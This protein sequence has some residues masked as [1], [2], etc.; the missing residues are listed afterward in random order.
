MTSPKTSAPAFND[1]T[2]IR[3]VAID[4]PIEA[5]VVGDALSREGIPHE[6]KSFHDTAYDGLFQA[7]MGWGEVRAPAAL[8]ER[9][10][11]IMTDIRQEDLS[12]FDP[13]E[14]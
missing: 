9:I 12:G 3:I 13:P 2:F 8:R 5:Q 7:Q 6:L 4:N 10:L 14:T 11:D 1:M